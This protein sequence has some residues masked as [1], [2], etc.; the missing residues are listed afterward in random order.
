MSE[1]KQKLKRANMPQ[2][3]DYTKEQDERCM[4]VAIKMVQIMIESGRLPE[5][6]FATVEE[7]NKLY[8]EMI[9]KMYPIMIDGKID[10]EKDLEY[11]SKMIGS[12]LFMLVE[13]IKA[14]LNRNLDLLRNNMFDEDDNTDNVLTIAQLSNL[15]VRRAKIREAVKVILAEPFEAQE[16]PK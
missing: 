15:T 5:N 7:K 11:I 4:P 14:S 6:S 8:F 9:Q 2:A 12:S 10:F 1:K 3:R 13:T 16:I